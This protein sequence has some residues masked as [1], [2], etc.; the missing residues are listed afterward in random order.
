LEGYNPDHQNEAM[1]DDNIIEDD[2][3][4]DV[5]N[6][7][8]EVEGDDLLDNM[9]QDYEERPELDRYEE[10]GLD[11]DDQNELSLEGRMQVDKR[12]DQEARMRQLGRRPGALMDEEYEEDDEMLQNQIRQERMRMMREGAIDHG[13]GGGGDDQDEDNVLDFEDVRGPLFVWLKKQD[14]IRYV[15]R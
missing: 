1:E 14:V 7:E 9:E 5:G 12:L 11:D 4:D 2:I 10:D 6:S 8:D 3:Q 13:M 15:K